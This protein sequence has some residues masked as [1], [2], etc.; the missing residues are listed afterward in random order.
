MLHFEH[1]DLDIARWDLGQHGLMMAA[2]QVFNRYTPDNRL[3]SGLED[4]N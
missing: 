1:I 3:D 2:W 4:Q